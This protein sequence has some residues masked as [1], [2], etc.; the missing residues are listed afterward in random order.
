VSVGSNPAT[1]LEYIVQIYLRRNAVLLS[2]VTR[3]SG[4]LDTPSDL[5]VNEWGAD[6]GN[7]SALDFLLLHNL[8]AHFVT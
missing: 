1:S 8:E 2:Q 4:L 3:E 6:V 7:S 5:V